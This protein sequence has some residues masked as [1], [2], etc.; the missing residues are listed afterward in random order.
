MKIEYHGQISYTFGQEFIVTLIV[1]L[2]LSTHIVTPLCS[3]RVYT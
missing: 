3:F 2:L 1:S